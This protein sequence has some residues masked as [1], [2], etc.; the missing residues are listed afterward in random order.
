MAAVDSSSFDSHD[1]EETLRCSGILPNADA[2][3]LW[4]ACG[5]VPVSN[6]DH[7]LLGMLRWAGVTE[8]GLNR[9][10]TPKALAR[11]AGRVAAPFVL[12][13]RRLRL[14]ADR[15]G[16]LVILTTPEQA[17]EVPPQRAAPELTASR[18]LAYIR[19]RYFSGRDATAAVFAFRNHNDADVLVTVNQRPRGHRGQIATLNV[20]DIYPVVKPEICASIVGALAERYC[21]TI[22]ALVLRGFDEAH[23]RAFRQRG[24]IR[25]QFD[26]P[27]GWFLDRSNLLPLVTGIWCL[28]TATG[29][30]DVLTQ[31]D[32]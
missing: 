20:L 26:A 18:D 14:D 6:S 32:I 23:Q 5:A 28:R 12:P 8:E 25:R 2:A 17:A 19:W 7:E 15:R 11:M 30:F 21:G 10:G 1:W 3:K 9:G 16:E 29:S 13:F 24:F 22:D 27:N 31:R 4:K